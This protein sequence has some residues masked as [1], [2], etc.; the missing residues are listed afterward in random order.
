M[1]VLLVHGGAGAA[2]PREEAALR[3]SLRRVV[4]RVWPVLTVRGALA[5]VVEAVRLLEDDPLF[6]AGT[7]SRLQADGVARLS[8]AVADGAERRF[9][10]VVNVEGLANPVLLAAALQGEVDRT[11]AGAGA[12]ARARALGLREADVRT[13]RRVREWQAGRVGTT[14]T[15]GAVAVDRRRR[16]AAATSTGGRGGEQPGRV[17]DSCTVAGTWAG[18]DAAVSTTGVG[19]H[20]VD[21][22]LA[23]RIGVAV[24]LGMPLGEACRAAFELLEA[25]EHQAGFVAVHADGTWSAAY[26]TEDMA[27]A[28][29]TDHRDVGWLADPTDEGEE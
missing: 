7:G 20:I 14:G 9:S 16:V 1:P 11:L 8:A 3:E 28:G 13:D 18:P 22:A 29:R 25:S 21:A 26:T 27:W 17:S 24:E 12:L 23:A 6:N 2:R 10:G 19:E 4:D 15:V 5:A